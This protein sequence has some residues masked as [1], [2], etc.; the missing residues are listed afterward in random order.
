MSALLYCGFFMLITILLSLACYRMFSRWWMHRR[1]INNEFTGILFGAVSLIQSLLIAFV[2]VA[3][4]EDYEELNQTIEEEADKLNSIIAHTVT[5]PDSLR[6]E[7]RTE[8]GRYCIKVI[9]EWQKPEEARID[10]A[11]AIPAIRLLLLEIQPQDNQQE[12]ILNVVDEDLNKISDLRRA[13]LSHLRSH[14]PALV[15]IILLT[16]SIMVIGF[17]F[18]IHTESA[19]LKQIGISFLTGIIAMSIFM[20]YTL[21]KP[22]TGKLI[23]GNEPYHKVLMLLKES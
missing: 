14:V 13:R 5:L 15:W 17:S 3:V 21:D 23:I 6:T 1:V 18:F 11:S 8:V 9:D 2:I 20:V 16:G 19:G 22:F 4:W 7:L 12:K 10:Q